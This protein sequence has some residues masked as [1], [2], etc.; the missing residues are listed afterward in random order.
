MLLVW[1]RYGSEV[2]LLCVLRPYG[3]DMVLVGYWVYIDMVLV[4]SWY[5][6]GLYWQGIDMVLISTWY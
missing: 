3:I 5:A 6:I 4:W 2:A 1:Y